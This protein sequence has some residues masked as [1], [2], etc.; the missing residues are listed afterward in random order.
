[1]RNLVLTTALLTA[2]GT[3][4]AYAQAVG[5]VPEGMPCVVT[6]VQPAD[7]TVGH[8]Y[9][10]FWCGPTLAFA[11]PASTYSNPVNPEVFEAIAASIGHM[12][13]AS[14]SPLGFVSLIGTT[15]TAQYVDNV[16]VQ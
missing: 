5:Q 3:S 13:T 8:N 6:A 12:V 7:A 2:L 1:M 9:N 16:K 4:A 10:L 14:V 15:G 11:T